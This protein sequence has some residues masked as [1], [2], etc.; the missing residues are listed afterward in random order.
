M[1]CDWPEALE[2]QRADGIAPLE[3]PPVSERLPFGTGTRSIWSTNFIQ[4]SS[5]RLMGRTLRQIPDRPCLRAPSRRKARTAPFLLRLRH[6]AMPFR[7][8]RGV[9]PFNCD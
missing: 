1:T 8:A 5:N 6:A 7:G 3:L 4:S 2:R 9:D